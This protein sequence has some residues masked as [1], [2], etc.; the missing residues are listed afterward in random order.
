M[1][2]NPVENPSQEDLISEIEIEHCQ[3]VLH[4]VAHA[5]IEAGD[6]IISDQHV[7]AVLE[8]GRHDAEYKRLKQFL[9]QGL[10]E[11]R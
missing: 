10:P 6:C 4:R 7:S 3:Q 9:E 2:R 1:S 11:E 5:D 8:E